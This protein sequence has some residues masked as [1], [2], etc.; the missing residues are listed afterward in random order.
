MHHSE[1]CRPSF[2]L[3]IL[4]VAEEQSWAG[5]DRGDDPHGAEPLHC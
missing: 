4:V 1:V 3:V 2:D 5:I